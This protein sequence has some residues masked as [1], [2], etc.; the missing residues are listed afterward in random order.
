VGS[1]IHNIKR[2][3]FLYSI[4]EK[5]DLMDPNTQSLDNIRTARLILTRMSKDYLNDLVRMYGDPQVMA[6]LGGVRS[7]S[8]TASYLDQQV[9]HWDQHG[10]GFWAALDA[11]TGQFVGRGGLRRGMVAGREEVEVGYGLLK[12]FWGRGL[13]TEIA[14]A[15][16]NAGFTI[17]QQADLVSFTLPTNLASRRVMEKAGF[18]YEKDIVYADLP[19]I[20]CRQTRD[21]WQATQNS[22]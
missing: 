16:M 8:Q 21:E 4:E 3:D 5:G 6:T 9:A 1:G 20:L 12:E 2:N 17:L 11:A 18:R 13:A 15:S 7:P 10:F 14:V 19:H 22:V